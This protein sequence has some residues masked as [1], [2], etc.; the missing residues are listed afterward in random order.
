ML[1]PRLIAISPE[2]FFAQR[3]GRMLEWSLHLTGG[4]RAA[5]SEER[6]VGKECRSLCDWSSDVCSSDLAEPPS[7]RHQP[8]RLFRAALRA[9]AGV[10]A[11]PDG[12]RPRGEIGRASCRER[13]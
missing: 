3:Y 1:N 4:D 11:T 10:V 13:V 8:R 7:N 2:D 12:R 5:R 9:D 6:R